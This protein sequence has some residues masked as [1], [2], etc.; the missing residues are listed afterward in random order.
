LDLRHIFEILRKDSKYDEIY[1]IL[2]KYYL[3]LIIIYLFSDE[4]QKD[5]I[6]KKILKLKKLKEIEKEE[7]EKEEKEKVN[8][9]FDFISDLLKSEAFI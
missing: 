9:G 4:K 7:I 5:K 6:L 3:T 2:I 8:L 1:Q